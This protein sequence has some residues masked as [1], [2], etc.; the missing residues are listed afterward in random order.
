M[1]IEKMIIV[2]KTTPYIAHVP[3]FIYSFI[4]LF[5]FF[6][7]LYP[8]AQVLFSQILFEM[9]FKI[10]VFQIILFSFQFLI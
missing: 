10:R 2:R 7:I 1:A 8:H 6:I 5:I 3:L 9:I 4:Y